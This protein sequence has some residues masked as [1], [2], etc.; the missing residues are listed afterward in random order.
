MS[1]LYKLIATLFWVTVIALVG[2][3]VLWLLFRAVFGGVMDRQTKAQQLEEEHNNISH[4]ENCAE[5][6]L[7]YRIRATPKGPE[8]D[9]LWDE[10]H[11]MEIEHK[12]AWDARVDEIVRLEVGGRSE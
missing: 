8:K 9:R 12:A 6:S 11:R 7:L 5:T 4:A 10:L 1:E 2:W 3:C